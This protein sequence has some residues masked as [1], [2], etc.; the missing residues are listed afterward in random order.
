MKKQFHDRGYKTLFSHPR[1]VEDL[2][3]AFVREPFVA[4][5][6]F[7]TLK[8]LATSFVTE[9]FRKRESDII[10]QV[11]FK[12]KP[13]YIYLL[14][15][16]QSSD[17]R[18]M[19]VRMLS[20]I[21]LLYLDLIKKKKFEK[22]PA[23]FPLLLYN[24]EERWQAAQEIT[25]LIDSPHKALI[26]YL[27]RF[28]YY[29]IAENEF[30]KAELRKLNNLAAQL[31]HIEMSDL[32]ELDRAIGRIIDVL[33]RNIPKEL[34]RDFGLWLRAK[35]RTKDRDLVITELN[36]MEVRPMLEKTMERFE[37]ECIKKGEAAGIE[38]GLVTGRLEGKLEGKL[39]L[40]KKLLA[41]GV[42]PKIIA[43]ASGLSVAK[44]KKLA[45]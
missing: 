22:L 19:A 18:F 33:K 15:E 7:S 32:G 21:T 1:M 37:Q 10:W 36:K 6:D 11:D 34:Q 44:I 8:K 35:L 41:A 31:F 2:F 43:K 3:R 13:A 39:E 23:V 9:E 12:G 29:K 42:D 26:P 4:D 16:F 27:P 14:I 40:A 30:P 25:E 38:K 20:Y 17:D 45:N 28:K 24:G 5:L